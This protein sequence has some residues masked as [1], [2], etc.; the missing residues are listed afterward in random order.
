M[1]ARRPQLT[2][3]QKRRSKRLSWSLL[4]LLCGYLPVA[5]GLVAPLPFFHPQ[6]RLALLLPAALAVGLVTVGLAN[7][8]IPF[9]R[10]EERIRSIESLL[11]TMQ[12]LMA[13]I[14]FGLGL[15]FGT[16]IEQGL[17]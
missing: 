16:L 14:L 8:L 13:M 10:R 7:W 12:L 15:A 5:L 6:R 2:P 17:R 3:K 11:S 4:Q 1:A 9:V